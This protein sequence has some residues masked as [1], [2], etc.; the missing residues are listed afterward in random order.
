MNVQD[1]LQIPEQLERLYS[2]VHLLKSL[3]HENIITCYHSWVDD[4]TKTINM[5]TELFTSGCLMQ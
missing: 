4:Q 1:A 2:K 5:I 3:K